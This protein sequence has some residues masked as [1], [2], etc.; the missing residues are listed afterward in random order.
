MKIRKVSQQDKEQLKSLVYQFYVEDKKRYS[1]YLQDREKY[2]NKERV[3]EET[4]NDYL[5][6]KKYLIYAAEK[7]GNL[8]GYTVGEVKEKPH[9]VFDKEGH[10]QDWFVT[11]GNRGSAIGKSLLEALIME[12]KRFRCTHIMLSAYFENKKAIEIYH[13][14]GFNNHLLVLRKDLK[15]L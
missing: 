3:I 9:K 14:M 2:K 4:V 1:E 11:E 13:K 5:S 12:F 8:V 10:V 7:E 15:L 6:D